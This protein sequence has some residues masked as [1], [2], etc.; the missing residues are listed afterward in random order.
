MQ[1][2]EVL[3]L[4]FPP[5]CAACRVPGSGLCARCFPCSALVSVR[6]PTL[7]VRAL[8]AYDGALRRAVLALKGGR[9]DV[10]DAL[11][12]R[13]AALTVDA[14]S[15]AV[16]VPVPTTRARRRD[17]GFDGCELMARTIARNTT[18]RASCGLTQVAGDAQRGRTRLER[19]RSQGRFRWH[20]EDLRGHRAVLIDDVV[21]TG[22]TLEDCA[23]VLR[24]AGAVVEEAF[25]I[26]VASAER[27]A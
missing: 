2:L 3:D 11:A 26:A 7:V 1:L 4:F 6:L 27:S 18:I 21:T 19:L 13:L 8:G 12:G 9:R 10:A 5:Q 16:F 23:A 25:A 14:G 24:A 22:A 17:R 20:G 15:G